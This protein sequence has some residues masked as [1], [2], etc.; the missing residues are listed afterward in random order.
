MVDH[1]CSPGNSCVGGYSRHCDWMCQGCADNVGAW[2]GVFLRKGVKARENVLMNPAH[3]AVRVCER[4]AL[5][6]RQRHTAPFTQGGGA[7][8][9]ADCKKALTCQKRAQYR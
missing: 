2:P 9:G 5:A 7:G 4:N 3:N 8:P 6:E 1:G